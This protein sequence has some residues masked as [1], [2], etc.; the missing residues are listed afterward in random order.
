MKFSIPP[1]LSFL[2]IRYGNW[3]R[4]VS[5][6]F[7][8]VFELLPRNQYWFWD[9][10][11]ENLTLNNKR[12]SVV[13]ISTVWC[14]LLFLSLIYHAWLLNLGLKSSKYAMIDTT[15]VVVCCVDGH[16]WWKWLGD[17]SRSY[18]QQ[19]PDQT[20]DAVL[21]CGCSYSGRRLFQTIFVTFQPFLLWYDKSPIVIVSSVK[22]VA[23]SSHLLTHLNDWRLIKI[24]KCSFSRQL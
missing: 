3:A 18:S 12:G 10:R 17:Y 23:L 14:I 21:R 6:S 11:G 24:I 4:V 19:F 13:T 20:E 2:R 7:Y 5:K 15:A 16:T 9:W 8:F 22:I 1:S